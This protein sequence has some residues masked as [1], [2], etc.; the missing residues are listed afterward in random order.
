MTLRSGKMFSTISGL[1]A[2]ADSQWN[3]FHDFSSLVRKFLEGGVRIVQLRMKNSSRD[4]VS[5]HAQLV[6]EL[7]K[8]FNFTFI[9]NDYAD[10][11]A[12][13][14][15]DGVHVGENDDPLP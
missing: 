1:Y 11:A 13:A 12:E 2:I 3:P 15:A 6:A 7:K 9:L 10:I 14:G 4:E 5:N 8:E